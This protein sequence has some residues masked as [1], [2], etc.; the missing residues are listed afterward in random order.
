[1]S[2]CQFYLT[3][4]VSVSV[5]KS[6]WAERLCWEFNLIDLPGGGIWA[7]AVNEKVFG[8]RSD[9]IGCIVLKR[10]THCLQNMFFFILVYIM[11]TLTSV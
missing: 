10:L 9:S 1:M 7:S 6:S 11:N 2:C 8:G 3:D 5:F 4:V